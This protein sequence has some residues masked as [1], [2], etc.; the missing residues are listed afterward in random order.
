MRYAA[1]LTSLLMSTML[2]AD[3]LDSLRA[4]WRNGELPDSS[5]FR[6]CYDLV[7]DGY[8]FSDPDSALI[9]AGELQQQARARNSPKYVALA[10][11][12]QAAGWY[13]KG[14]LRKALS[15]YS[16]S[17]PMHEARGDV[18]SMA[19]VIGNMA[20]MYSFLGE[21]EKALT[22]YGKALRSHTERHDT[23]GMATDINAIGSVYMVRGEHGRAIDNFRLSLRMQ[24]AIGNERGIATGL[25]NLGA[26]HELQ[27]DHLA[28]LHRYEEALPLAQRLSDKD[29]MANILVQIGSC[30]QELG[31]TAKAMSSLRQS[32]GLCRELGDQRGV[33]TALNKMGELLRSEHRPAEAW[34]LHHEALPIAQEH[35]LTFGLV[36]ALIGAAEAAIDL[37]RPSE[38]LALAQRAEKEARSSDDISLERDAVDLLYR[39]HRRAGHVKDAL[40]YHER[41]VLLRDS[42]MREENQREALHAQYAYDH[43][44]HTLADSLRYQDEKHALILAHAE[45]AGKD[46]RQR[47][48]L[49]AALVL[50]AI[51]AFGTW[52]RLRHMARTNRAI[53]EAQARTVAAERALEAEAVRT[54]IAS[55][56]HDEM[57]G[58]L[59]KI[60]LLSSETERL[61]E[62]DPLAARKSLARI[63][64]L[65]RSAS[66]SLHDVV[67]AVDPAADNTEALV[68]Q[69]RALAERLL[70]GSDLHH[71]LRM[72]HG[73]P[74]RSVDPAVRRDMLLLLKEAINNAL[75]YAE[76]SCIEVRCAIHDGN[77]DLRVQDNGRGFD[78]QK[79]QEGRGLSNMRAR[80]C[81]LGLSYQLES[82][83]GIGTVITSGGLLNDGLP[84]K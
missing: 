76:A 35:E 38:A 83:P 4:S 84:R 81:R 6:A 19:D 11:D 77:L 57:G 56:I 41:F 17:L 25:T 30:Q 66:G 48:W 45:R 68:R 32:L 55:D 24:H 47:S 12:L 27:G 15:L 42:I 78:P 5:R 74:E 58:E 28:A 46:G 26:V 29:Q 9:L 44:R 40:H 51:V 59:T 61:F 79:V 53:R 18:G 1:L 21:H 63:G 7:W 49:I 67:H 73:G 75:K 14:D 33:I 16:I 3:G 8:L 31:D 80:A 2:V 22:L 43:E 60:G 72:E 37:G 82:S 36:T 62:G 54:R 13:V 50:A 65:A 39:L 71:Q 52:S 70:G 69:A 10:Y 64:E 20:S 23:L 34:R